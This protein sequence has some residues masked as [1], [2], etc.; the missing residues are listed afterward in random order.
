MKSLTQHITEKLVINRNTEVNGQEEYFA[1]ML[2]CDKNSEFIKTVIDFINKPNVEFTA[3]GDHS[4]LRLIAEALDIDDSWIKRFKNEPDIEDLIEG[5]F[6]VKEIKDLSGTGFKRCSI[7]KNDNMFGVDA[8]IYVAGAGEYS[9][10]V[11]FE[12]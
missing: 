3:L 11:I 4:E 2:L 1:E 10:I 9:F 5:S 8:I 6:D 12:Y 7:A